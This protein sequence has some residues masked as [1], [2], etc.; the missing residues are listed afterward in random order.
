M[1][2]KTVH[3]KH[4]Q[5]PIEH[6]MSIYPPPKKRR[7]QV[8]KGHRKLKM[9]TVKLKKGTRLFNLAKANPHT[10][11]QTNNTQRLQNP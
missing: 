6:I 10:H 2:Q 11:K 7:P 1:Q 4:I 9:V 3:Q 8:Q 5:L